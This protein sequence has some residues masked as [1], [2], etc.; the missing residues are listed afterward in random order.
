VTVMV[1]Q[2]CGEQFTLK[3][4]FEAECPEC[5]CEDLVEE[6]A[7]DLLERE[8]QCEF[9]GYVIDT[10]AAEDPEWAEPG[11]PREP[12]SVDDP[13]PI[14]DSALVPMAKAGPLRSLPE[15]K[16]ARAA[17][18]KLHR[19]H[20]IAGPP[21]ELEKLAQELG[22]QVVTGSFEHDGLLVGERIELPESATAPA[23]RFALAHEIGHHVLRHEGE[24]SKV[25]PEANAF[26]SELLVPRD[27]LGAAVEAEPSA[28]ALARRFGVSRQAMVYAL[29]SARKIDRIRR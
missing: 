1:C 28:R 25:E 7:Y 14:C 29:M 2:G 20:A 22:L 17:A 15:Y 18:Q 6:N 27:E 11:G 9:C 4:R 13:C 5:G 21:Y 10:S 12:E 19:E 26:A 8:L 23:R 24:R 16:L 3:S